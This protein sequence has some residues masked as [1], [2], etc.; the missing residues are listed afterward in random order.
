MT[1][2]QG[3]FHFQIHPAANY[4]SLNITFLQT[5]EKLINGSSPILK[6]PSDK[7]N[8]VR[9]L[10]NEEISVEFRKPE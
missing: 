2:P 4:I 6:S 9:N 5:L 10:V 8:H 7:S 1:L 3:H